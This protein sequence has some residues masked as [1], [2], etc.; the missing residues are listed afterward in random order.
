MESL[1]RQIVGVAIVDSLALSFL[2]RKTRMSKTI[3]DDID[4]KSR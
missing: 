2:P 3:R 4:V 1:G